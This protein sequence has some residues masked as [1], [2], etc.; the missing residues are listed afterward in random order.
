MPLFLLLAVFGMVFSTEATAKANPA[1]PLPPA[2]GDLLGGVQFLKE[3]H[4]DTV[5][6]VLEVARRAKAEGIGIKLLSGRRSCAQQNAL[7]A[8]G[9]TAPGPVVTGAR[10]CSSWHVQGRAVDFLPSPATEAAYARVGAI[11]KEL[12][13]VWGGQFSNLRDLGHIEYHPGMKISDVCPDPD[14]C[15]DPR[16]SSTQIPPSSSAWLMPAKALP[17][18]A[19]L[20][21]YQGQGEPWGQAG[22]SQFAT[23]QEREIFLA[24]AR[25]AV[26]L[27]QVSATPEK[28]PRPL[29]FYAV[30]LDNGQP[31]EQGYLSQI[32]GNPW[33]PFV[34][35][36]QGV[37]MRPN[38]STM[39]GADP[40]PPTGIPPASQME[41][42]YAAVAR[43]G[44]WSQWSQFGPGTLSQMETAIKLAKKIAKLSGAQALAIGRLVLDAYG[45]P[46]PSLSGVE[47]VDLATVQA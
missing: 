30:I 21:T 42:I 1:P 34:W 36:G 45:Q 40:L 17:Y 14:R 5:R 47:M 11:A 18:G 7:Y 27:A 13:G 19:I 3:L 41:T 35:G 6:F 2:G 10:G 12:G 31:K 20:Y 25:S 46:A 15:L 44:Q 16:M 38:L 39:S 8:Q 26:K 23:P 28:P 33:P 37:S 24:G 22:Y 43:G 32:R 9:R 29:D 4:P